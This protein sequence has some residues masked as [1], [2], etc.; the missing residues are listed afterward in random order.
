MKKTMCIIGVTAVL[1]LGLAAGTWWYTSTNGVRKYEQITE[2]YRRLTERQALEITAI[3]QS[4]ELAELK[5]KLATKEKVK[6]VSE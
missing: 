3:K 4:V 2:A 6:Q 5:E 1:I